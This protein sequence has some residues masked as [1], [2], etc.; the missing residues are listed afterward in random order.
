MSE[1]DEIQFACIGCGTMN[2]AKAEVC[3][4]AGSVPGAR[5]PPPPRVPFDPS[6]IEPMRISS[7]GG[8][9]LARDDQGVRRTRLFLVGLGRVLA[10]S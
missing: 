9:N 7:R 8:R 4:V 5:F 3:A 6:R 1:P 10:C 2:P